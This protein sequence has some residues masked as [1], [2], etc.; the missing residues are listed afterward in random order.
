MTKVTKKKQ[1][2]IQQQTA[3]AGT[4]RAET[5]ADLAA[6]QKLMNMARQELT[7]FQIEQIKATT[8]KVKAETAGLSGGVN[9]RDVSKA[10]LILKTSTEYLTAKRKT[11]EAMETVFWSSF[12]NLVDDSENT[13]PGGIKSI[14]RS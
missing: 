14:K 2:E 11:Q 10:F 8:E 7:G 1:L 13:P 5:D 6:S 3:D 9:F 12:P 4:L